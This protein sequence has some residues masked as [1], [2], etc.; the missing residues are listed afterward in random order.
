VSGNKFGFDPVTLNP[1]A[2]CNSL[3]GTAIGIIIWAAFLNDLQVTIGGN[4]LIEA[5]FFADVSY[6]SIQFDGN[7]PAPF[8][9]AIGYV[10]LIG[11]YFG[12]CVN[13]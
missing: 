2:E 13:P 6:Q 9:T 1:T 12:K 4:S 11:N 10:N 8:P 3:T 7:Y 5:N